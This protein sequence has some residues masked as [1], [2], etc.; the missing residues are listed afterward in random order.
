MLRQVLLQVT[1]C[2]SQTLA[3]GWR[4]WFA[5]GTLADHASA[6]HSPTASAHS[7]EAA[8]GYWGLA[9]IYFYANELLPNIYANL[10]SLNLAEVAGISPELA[11]SYANMCIAAGLVPLHAVAEAY[12]RRARDT[13]ESLDQYSHHRA[14]VLLITA[15]YNAGVGQWTRA[16]DA[17]RQA[18][19]ISE[20]L[21]D[22]RRWEQS[23]NTLAT[24]TYLQGEFT[25]SAKL[26]GELY[27]SAQRRGDVQYQAYGLLGQ[28]RCR[29]PLGQ[30]EKAAADMDAVEA[31]LARKLGRVE[32]ILAYGVKALVCLR[33]G[34]QAL[35]QQAAERVAHLIEQSR[36]VSYTL[37]PAYAGVAEVYLALWE[38]ELQADANARMWSSPPAAPSAPHAQPS[39]IPRLQAEAQRA[40]RTLQGFA[41]VFPI[42]Q[43]RAWLWEGLYAWLS[44]KPARAHKA[45]RKS[46]AS[47]ERLKMPYEQGL[48]QY[49]MGQH[50]TGADRQRYLTC[51]GEIFSRIGA[52]YDLGRAQAA[53]ERSDALASPQP[54]G[55]VERPE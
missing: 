49:E 40:C 21:G 17:L 46:L 31:L 27:A 36:P 19:E 12:S 42:A 10:R 4:A 30:L 1:H 41:R 47:A 22:R 45:W 13:A 23:F 43:P 5:R 37:L 8:R 53:A 24:V 28:A 54:A 44:G 52:T 38:A 9:Q 48:A 15:V 39:A 18:V 3:K 2:L 20:H 26:F 50:T 6:H 25:H 11:R 7:L 35:A 55:S 14:W 51:A 33:Q 32:E 29:L 34:E 16:Q